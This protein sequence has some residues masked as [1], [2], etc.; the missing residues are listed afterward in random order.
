VGRGRRQLCLAARHRRAPPL[1]RTTLASLVA[2]LVPLGSSASIVRDWS[3]RAGSRRSKTS[4]RGG[5]SS[6]ST[7][8]NVSQRAASLPER[9]V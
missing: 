7:A 4:L 3:M 8:V 1:M 5:H 2:Q 6:V 9:A